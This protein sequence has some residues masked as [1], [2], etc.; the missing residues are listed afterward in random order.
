[1]CQSCWNV[2]WVEPV[3]S[4]GSSALVIESASCVAQIRDPS[5]SS[6]ALFNK[7]SSDMRQM[8]QNKWAATWYFQQCTCS[9]CDQ[10]SLRPACAYAPSDQSHCRP[11]E[12]SE[13]KATTRTS[14]GV[15]KLKSS[16]E[17]TL[18]KIPHFWKSHVAAQVELYKNL[19]TAV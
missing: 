14:F 19:G 6:R 16:S 11:L 9:L 10:Q 4:R 3:L 8:V 5:I 18:V 7:L 15:S 12:D 1:M 17:S 13:C 2:S